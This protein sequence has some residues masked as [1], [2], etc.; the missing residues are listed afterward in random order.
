MDN[1]I[2]NKIRAQDKTTKSGMINMAIKPLSLLCSL[3]YTP[4]LL[5]YLGTEKYGLWSTVL[6]MISWINYFDVGIGNGLRDILPK[7]ITKNKYEDAKKAVSTAYICIT[8][9]SLSIL[10]ILIIFTSIMNWQSIFST[11][12]DMRPVLYISFGFI[13]INFILSLINILLYALELSEN[14]SLRNLVSQ[15]I[16]IIG[17]L[18]LSCISK[19]S[20]VYIAI[21][22]GCS[23]ALVYIETSLKL[24][25]AH[26]YLAPSIKLFDKKF[27]SSIAKTGVKF[28]VIQIMCL[29]IFTTDELLITHFW[30]A[31]YLTPFSIANR[32]YNT[33]YSILAAFLVPFWS[34]TTI[35]ISNKDYKWIIRSIKK[36]FKLLFIFILLFLISIFAFVPVVTLWLGKKLEYQPGLIA[37]MAIFYSLYSILAVE[38]QFINGSGK[39]NAQLVMYIILGVANIPLSIFLGVNVGLKAAGIRLATLILVLIADIV[40][41][42]NLYNIIRGYRATWDICDY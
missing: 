28:F 4:L 13:C 26:K 6:S 18:I 24:W 17:V 30:G 23:Q 34:G 31:T 19:Q 35:A 37:I 33:G 10:A 39:I 1:K 14:V 25:K 16:N 3:I 32:V 36:S 8:I 40:L 9:I 15:I 11:N 7:L 5:D 12:I 41:G 20:L 29:L 2:L 22:F 38:C 21:L 42:I 27:L